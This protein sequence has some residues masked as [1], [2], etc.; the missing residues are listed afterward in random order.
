MMISITTMYCSSLTRIILNKSRNNIVLQS[1]SNVVLHR[2]WIFGEK[3]QSGF[4]KLYS[5]LGTGSKAVNLQNELSCGSKTK[6][7]LDCASLFRCVKWGFQSIPHSL[8]EQSVQIVKVCTQQCECVLAH[9]IRRGQ[10]MFS[11]YSKLWDEVALKELF[12]KMRQQL[13]RK[14]KAFVLSAIGISAYNWEKERIPDEELCGQLDEMKCV[15][16]LRDFTITCPE[17]RK[18]MMVDVPLPNVEYCSCTTEHKQCLNKNLSGWHPFLE[19]E[20]LLVWRKECDNSQGLYVY[21]VYGNY[22]EVTAEDFL[23]VQIDTE[24]RMV[25]DNTAINLEIVD[26]DNK[27]NSDVVYWEM[28]YLIDKENNIIVIINRG[29]EHP[30]VPKKAENHRVT[31]YWS[32]MVIK[33]SSNIEQPG[34]EFSLTYFDNPG[35]SIPPSITAWVAMSGLPD[36]QVRLRQAARDYKSYCDQVNKSY[37][38]DEARFQN[39]PVSDPAKKDSDSKCESDNSPPKTSPSDPSSDQPVPTQEHHTVTPSTSQMFF[40]KCQVW[41]LFI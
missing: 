34:M 36:F 31:D 10:Q 23:R 25:W 28:E 7:S 15:H 2:K 19:R 32:V 1:R 29:T 11:L 17:C 18:R 8:K 16:E 22:P 26:Q 41:Q 35:V 9:R 40:K 12:R 30:S 3:F 27:S 39:D 13:S 14:G 37:K 24:F 38:G 20:D 5:L 33:A 4:S 21:K 6:L